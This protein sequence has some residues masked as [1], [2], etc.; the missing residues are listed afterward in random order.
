M[1]Y[2]ME[3][4]MRDRINEELTA[5]IKGR[6]KLRTATLRL[7]NAAIKDRDIAARGKGKEN[8]ADEDILVLLQKM[9][10]QRAES[11][12]IYQKAGREELEQQER[13]EVAVIEEFLPKPLGDDEVAAEIEAAIAATD[14]QSLRDMGKVVG[15][16]KAK[17][18]GRIDFG[19]ASKLVKEKLGAG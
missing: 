7:M 5:A 19:K 9:I 4:G 13:D 2:E 3:S 1:F 10:K 6:N 14:A 12:E 17:F 15:A 11:I 16:L 18:P 8:I